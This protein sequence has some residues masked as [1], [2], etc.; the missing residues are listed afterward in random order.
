MAPARADLNSGTKAFAVLNTARMLTPAMRS[1]SA[2]ETSSIG[3]G[4]CVTPALLTRMSG[5]PNAVIAASAI[6]L[7]LSALADIDLMHD[8]A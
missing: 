1:K 6:A 3:I 7:T 2:S 4:R 5:V 8:R